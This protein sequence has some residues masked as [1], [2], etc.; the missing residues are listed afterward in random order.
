MRWIDGLSK[1]QR[2]VVVIAFGLVLWAVGS[3]LVSLGQGE[4]AVG[5]YAY[6]P[7]TSGPNIPGRGLHPWVRVIIWL[8]LIGVWALASV[9]VLRPS[10]EKAPS[11]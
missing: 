11:D 3:Y 2:V 4:V 8:V 6:S 10:S 1:A 9:R 5:W 7:L